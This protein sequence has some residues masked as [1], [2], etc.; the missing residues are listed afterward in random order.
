[1]PCRVVILGGGVAGM[2]AAHEL[3]ERGFEVVVLER[4][5]V[6]GGKARS[7]QVTHDGADTSSP[8]WPRERQRSI[9]ACRA[10]TDSGSF[11]AS[12]S[13]SSTPCGVSHRSMGARWRIIS[14]RRRAWASRNTESLRF[15][16]PMVFPRTPSDAGMLLRDILAAFGPIADLTPEELAFFGARLWQILTSCGERRLAEYERINWW[17]FV[18]AERA[19]EVLP[20]VPRGRLDALAGGLQGA[21]GQHAHDR[22]HLRAAD[23][24][25]A[26]SNRRI[27]RSRPRW[28]DESRLDR[29]MACLS[30]IARA[31]TTHTKSEVEEILCDNG[32]ITGVAVNQDGKRTLVQGDHYIAALP[33]ERI[34]PLVN[35]ALLAAA[36]ALANLAMLAPNVEWMNGVQFYLHRDVP[37]AHGHVIHIDTEW[38][39]TSISQL[40]F[41][42][43]V[44]PEQ[45]G[46]SDVRGIIS[47]DV[48]DW[49]A[50]GGNGRPAMYCSREEAVRETWRQLK[51]SIN[52]EQE[53]LAR[54][55]SAFVVPRPGY[56]LS[57]LRALALLRNVEPLLV[58]LVDTWAL[59]PEATTA[60]SQSV[61]GVGL[62]AHLHRPRHHGRR[63]RSGAT[64][65]ERLARRRELRWTAL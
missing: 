45:F 34:A 16:V 60:H 3:S 54:R 53:L 13:T 26:R 58:N 25:G 7:V 65:G 47:V 51:T 36:P 28:S 10:S 11:P 35:R 44:P 63:Q 42:R 32:R 56:R 40:Q 33:L 17:E 8:I 43:N 22:R 64:R 27:D 1:M 20:E 23:A 21:P 29:S 39:L 59:R 52:A 5:Y 61:S 9:I 18:D 49:T 15:V 50:P 55:G 38:A 46:D 31:C 24:H 14:C 12:T 41:W 4:R 37:T 6:P 57:I 62:C 2:S 30:Q 48:S 19:L